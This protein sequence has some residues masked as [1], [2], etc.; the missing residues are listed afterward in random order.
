VSWLPRHDAGVRGAALA[1]L[2]VSSSCGN[3][4]YA[5]RVTQ[6]SQELARA[7]QLDAARRAPYDYYYALEHLK[8]ARSE[9]GEADY[10]DAVALAEKAYQHANRAVQIA[11]R[12]APAAPSL[13]LDSP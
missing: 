6:A 9:A 7:E 11:Q 1:G 12:V 2:L 10:S 13:H 8:K 4:L 5:T 3:T